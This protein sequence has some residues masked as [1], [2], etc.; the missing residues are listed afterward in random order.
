M[1][2]DPRIWEGLLFELKNPHGVST[3]IFT[4]KACLLRARHRSFDATYDLYAG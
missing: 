4:S 1:R 3:E 2:V